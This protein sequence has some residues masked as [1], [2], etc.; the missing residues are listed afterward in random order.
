MSAIDCFALEIFR[1][2][3]SVSIILKEVE[4]KIGIE[5]AD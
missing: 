2:F 3:D 4:W 1:T 5:I